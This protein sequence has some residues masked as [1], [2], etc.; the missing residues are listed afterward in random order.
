MFVHFLIIFWPRLNTCIVWLI[1]GGRSVSLL[2]IFKSWT[3][4]SKY[5][6]VWDGEE[7]YIKFQNTNYYQEKIFT[8]LFVSSVFLYL[9]NLMELK[10]TKCR[11]QVSFS[12]LLLGCLI[13]IWGFKSWKD[14][15]SYSYCPQNTLNCT[16]LAICVA[17]TQLNCN[18]F[19]NKWNKNR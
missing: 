6:F 5:I 2:I 1:T 17:S 16:H 4:S 14:P 10:K 7:K 3:E 19:R 12:I 15:Y 11:G 9:V 13:F 8:S 18:T